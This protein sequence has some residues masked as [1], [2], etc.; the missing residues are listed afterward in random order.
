ML[1]E[2]LQHALAVEENQNELD[3]ELI[4]EGQNMTSLCAGL[5]VIDSHTEAVTLVHYTTK[6]YF[7]EH[8]DKYFPNFHGS[9]TM[10]C[11][12][13]LAMPVLQNATVRRIVRDYPL[14]CYAAQYMADHARENLEETL[15]A[16][17][18]ENL[19]QQSQPYL[20][21]NPTPLI[22]DHFLPPPN[23]HINIRHS[24]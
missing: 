22:M 7:E 1:L 21:T 23:L 12:T 13:Y 19:H 15:E 4:M 6:K 2:E 24:V 10:S 3:E 17:T 14:A 18:L 16:S 5:V 9:I 11:A 20:C 8:R